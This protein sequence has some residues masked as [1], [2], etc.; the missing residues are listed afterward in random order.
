MP[1]GPRQYAREHA[2]NPPCFFRS[3]VS[4]D[5]TAPWRKEVPPNAKFL[6]YLKREGEPI[7]YDGEPTRYDVAGSPF[8]DHVLRFHERFMIYECL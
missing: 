1:G 3:N 6:F 4:L 5:E 2:E 8:Y 7:R